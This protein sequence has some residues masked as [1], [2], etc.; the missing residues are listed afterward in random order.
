MKNT[1]LSNRFLSIQVAWKELIHSSISTS[2]IILVTAAI[3]LPILIL[4]SLKEGYLDILKD[5]FYKSNQATRIDI[6]ATNVN[7]EEQKIT[8]ARISEYELVDGVKAVV[9]ARSHKVYTYEE[10]GDGEEVSFDAISTIPEDPDLER[11]SFNGTL[12]EEDIAYVKAIIMHKE[13]VKVLGYDTI[14]AEIPI[15]VKRS[16]NNMGTRSYEI[17][18]RLLGTVSGGLRGR[19]YV[20][21]TFDKEIE[22]FQIGLS[23]P[24]LGLPADPS[25]EESLTEP[26][27]PDCLVL[28]RE[29]LYD[30]EREGLEIDGDKYLIKAVDKDSLV[31]PS[32]FFYQ[33]SPSDENT[34]ISEEKRKLISSYLSSREIDVI[35]KVESLWINIEGNNVELQT[36]TNLRDDMRYKFFLERGRWLNPDRNRFEIVV[37]ESSIPKDV[38]LPMDFKQK[39]GEDT[40]YFSIQGTTTQ[41]N[42]FI[43]FAVLNRLKELEEGKVKLGKNSQYFETTSDNPYVNR[44]LMAGIHASTIDDVLPLINYFRDEKGY[45]IFG[46]S[47]AK[48]KSIKQYTRL[49]NNFTLLISIAGILAGITALWVLMYEAIKRKKNQIGIMR[50][51]GL[52][53]SFIIQTYLWQSLAY[54]LGGFLLSFILFKTIITFFLESSVGRTI[55]DIESIEGKVFITPPHLVFYFI[56]GILLVSLVAGRSAAQS[57]KNVDPADILND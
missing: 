1:N 32:V 36:S 15:V 33:I 45:E 19:I 50:A 53:Q 8:E 47:E 10:A 9:P 49:L 5:N 41:S 21:M 56:I 17:R 43:D 51:M 12:D 25:S 29:P 18:C 39:I 34:V 54:G 40:V 35:P 52:P 30:L 48:V 55:L 20:P 6:L 14:P 57:I 24:S 2:L 22:L 38:F 4:T 42:G 23:A 11:F 26:K 28:S 3:C 44:Y 37:P 7:M 46:S 31:I 13:D 27:Y 16:T